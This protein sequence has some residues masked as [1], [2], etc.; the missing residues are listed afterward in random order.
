MVGRDWVLVAIHDKR[1]LRALLLTMETAVVSFRPFGT[2][3]DFVGPAWHGQLRCS[4]VWCHHAVRIL[5]ADAQRL[6]TDLDVV[7]L[8]GP[9][10]FIFDWVPFDLVTFFNSGVVPTTEDQLTLV[11]LVG[12]QVEG[13]DVRGAISRVIEHVVVDE[14]VEEWSNIRFGHLRVGQTDDSVEAA[15]EARLGL[16]EAELVTSNIHLVFV[17]IGVSEGHLICSEISSQG[18]ATEC[19]LDALFVSWFLPSG[20]GALV[21]SFEVVSICLAFERLDADNPRVSRTSVEESANFLLVRS[22]IDRADVAEI[23][24]VVHV[25]LDVALLDHV[26]GLGLGLNLHKVQGAFHLFDLAPDPAFE[27]LK[28]RLSQHALFWG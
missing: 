1:E 27:L 19:D 2:L 16:H 13:E 28:L 26:L 5:V 22:E 7:E 12:R 11:S 25:H 8:D 3:P 9:E 17:V 24:V 23:P 21:K 15:C 10:E 4:R 20:R 14:S 18:A 6:S